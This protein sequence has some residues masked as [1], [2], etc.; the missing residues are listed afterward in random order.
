MHA[1]HL[2]PPRSIEDTLR[3][4]SLEKF[5]NFDKQIAVDGSSGETV[6]LP[7]VEEVIN[8]RRKREATEAVQEGRVQD[9]AMLIDTEEIGK[10]AA[11]RAERK[12]AAMQ[13][14][15]MKPREVDLVWKA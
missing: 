11:K 6:D 7:T 12:A 5:M 3:D 10:K 15:V 14:V 4:R 8:K 1:S 9:A 2:Q 13:R